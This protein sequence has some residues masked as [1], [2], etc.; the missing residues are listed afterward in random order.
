MFNQAICWHNTL[1]VN[2]SYPAI[3]KTTSPEIGCLVTGLVQI[4]GIE[5]ARISPP[6]P[7]ES[8]TTGI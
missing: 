6:E 5:P 8:G 2:E 3:P 1:Y 7:N 4:T